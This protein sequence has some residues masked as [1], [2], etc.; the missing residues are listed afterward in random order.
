MKRVLKYSSLTGAIGAT[1]TAGY[2]VVVSRRP[3]SEKLHVVL[4]L[5]ATILQSFPVKSLKNINHSNVR[6][7]DHTIMDEE[8]DGGKEGYLIWHRPFAHSSL[9]FLNQLFVVHLFTAATKNYGEACLHSFPG[10]FENQRFYRESVTQKDS[11]GK[12]LSLITLDTDKIVLVDDQAR[13][14]TGDQGFYHIPPYT[15]FVRFD[16]ELPKLCAWTVYWQISHDRKK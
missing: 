15:R 9:W 4:D 1:A 13:N 5:D 11:H 8:D 6:S 14:R 12:D 16:F 2:C 7:H 3:A 10:L